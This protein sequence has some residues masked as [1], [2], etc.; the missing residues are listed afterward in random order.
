[1]AAMSNTDTDAL[2]AGDTAHDAPPALGS[3]PVDAGG[4]PTWLRRTIIAVVLVAGVG[5]V[6]WGNGLASNGDGSGGS[7]DAAIVKLTPESG[8]QVPRQSPVGADLAPG[9]DGRLT[10]NGIAIPEE[11]MVGARDPATV[12]PADLARNGVRPNNRNSVYFQPGPGKVIEEY[13]QGPVVIELRYFRER[14]AN[15]SRTTSWQ[16]RVD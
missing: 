4:W 3:P 14:Q 7:L 8:A 11:Q 5:L 13:P 16:I 2:A 1:M 10:I 12:D 15:T 9:Y 6:I